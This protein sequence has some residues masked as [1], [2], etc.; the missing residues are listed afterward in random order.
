MQLPL[1]IT[2]LNMRPSPLVKK[3]VTEEVAKLEE[4]Y[5]RIMGC[6]VVVELPN[7]RHKSGGLYQIRIDLTVPGEEL[8]VRRQPSLHSELQH[9]HGTRMHKSIELKA[10]HRDLRQTIDDAFMVMGRRLEDFARR[11]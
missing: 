4:F 10:P 9:I 3:W 5:P 2:F 6:R 7:R 1:Q 11:Q 8:V